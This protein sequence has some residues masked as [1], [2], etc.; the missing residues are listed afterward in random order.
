M[1]VHITPSRPN[2][3]LQRRFA[4]RSERC[5]GYLDLARSNRQGQFRSQLNLKEFVM[6]EAT[7]LEVVDLGDAKEQTKGIVLPGSEENYTLPGRQ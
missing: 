7:E 5:T 1:C 2:D 3:P 6:N 4:L